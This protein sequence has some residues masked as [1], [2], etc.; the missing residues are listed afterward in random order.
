MPAAAPWRSPS[1]GDARTR[2]SGRRPHRR[3]ALEARYRL[4]VVHRIM[5]ASFERRERI[6]SAA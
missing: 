2:R 5:S 3:D 6:M 1:E 4:V